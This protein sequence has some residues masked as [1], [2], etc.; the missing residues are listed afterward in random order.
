MAFKDI[1]RSRQFLSPAELGFVLGMLI[2]IA[3][4]LVLNIHI[5]RT[6]E[7]GKWLYL[8]WNGSRAYLFDHIDP[9]SS[10]IAERVQNL[11]YGRT[12]YLN[13]YP[14][15]LDDP[16]YIVLLYSPLALISDFA[17]ARGIWM[18]VSEA[19]IIGIIMLSLR[20]AE[21]EPP[22]WMFA[23]LIPF[24]LFGYISVDA[25]LSASPA[26]FLVLIYLG[27]LTAINNGSDELAGALLFLAAYQWEVGALFF[28]FI[29]VM[30]I[31]HRRWS[32]L[33]GF[34]MTAVVLLISSLLLNS[35]W[36]IPY[37]R[38]V[39]F[40]WLHS[41]DYTFGILLSYTFPQMN[42]SLIGW[43]SIAIFV[44]MMYETIR[45]VLSRPRHLIWA[46]FLSLALN[47]LVG[48]A[49]FSTNHIVLLP[50][51]ILVFALVSER[52]QGVRFAL[53][54]FVVVLIFAILPAGLY[55][56]TLRS[57]TRLYSDLLRFLPPLLAVAGL[58]WMRWWAIR[59]PRL[60]V[61]QI[62]ERK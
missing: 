18:L 45:S 58:Y 15:M 42:E 29:A 22:I 55:L 32:L 26:V 57:P 33:T 36:V 60:W 8:R 27:I 21:W 39:I 7:G 1:R 13:E 48:F 2:L 49:I 41:A 44:L 62:G 47:P 54:I 40:N 28:A 38:A 5:A 11:V 59:P 16:F 14:Y 19:A 6:M 30:V 12:A 61:D 23:I 53:A 50:A 52:W 3:G 31:A 24:G 51:L 43:I 9:Y 56:Q 17:V 25:I 37:G 35:G 4:L 10:T 46:I 20:F 34:A